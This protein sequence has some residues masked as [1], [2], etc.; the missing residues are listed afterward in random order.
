MGILHLAGLGRSPGALTSGLSYLARRHGA[1][2]KELGK[3]VDEVIVFTSPEV[4]SGT[5]ATGGEVIL[6]RYGSETYCPRKW[7]DA[8][9][10]EV[11]SECFAEQ[12]PDAKLHVCVVDLQDFYDCLRAV[13]QTLLRFHRAGSVGRHV[14][15]NLTGGTNILNSALFLG[16]NLSGL[17]AKF[18]YTF[19]P[20]QKLRYLMP[21]AE[22]DPLLFRYQEIPVLTTR[23]QIDEVL[24]YL[25]STL[26]AQQPGSW[27][28]ESD[29]AKS[30]ASVL[31]QF[32]LDP[33]SFR[34][35]YLNVLDQQFIE[36]PGKREDD[37][38]NPHHEV[39][40]TDEGRKLLAVME[41]AWF[42]AL[43][44]DS[45][46]PSSSKEELTRGLELKQVWPKATE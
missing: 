23:G 15:I 45:T 2:T 10:L 46:L 31:A 14:Q 26:N 5:L 28:R 24:Y 22:N 27:L 9:V 40:I 12:F 7:T 38:I 34:R 16:A 35:D 19:V 13:G 25:L 4:A 32:S 33:L 1:W 18:Y 37:G 41:S 30:M 8:P 3:V 11:L 29:L 20:V 17:V 44:R 6:N 36:R 39:R 42:R 21:V 43:H